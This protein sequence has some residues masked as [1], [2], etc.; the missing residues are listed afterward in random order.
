MGLAPS[1]QITEKERG[2]ERER[3]RRERERETESKVDAADTWKEED[4]EEARMWLLA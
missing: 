3:E 1:S 4:E 2:R